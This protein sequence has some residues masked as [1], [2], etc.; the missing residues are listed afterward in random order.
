MTMDMPQ[1]TRP[2]ALSVIRKIYASYCAI[3]Y[4]D[5]G[6]EELR[7]DDLDDHERAALVEATQVVVDE[8]FDRVE[9]FLYDYS[10]WKEE[11]LNNPPPAKDYGREETGEYEKLPERP[12]YACGANPVWGKELLCQSCKS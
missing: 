11:Q 12:C 7:W 5:A 2:T 6:R 1:F 3:L 8:E 10:R 9:D 4:A